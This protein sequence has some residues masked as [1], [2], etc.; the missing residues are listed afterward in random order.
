ML[1]AGH[2]IA[3]LLIFLTMIGASA[4]CGQKGDLYLPDK[5]EQQQD[6]APQARH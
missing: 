1:T 5:A 4:G 6:Y 2:R 3:M